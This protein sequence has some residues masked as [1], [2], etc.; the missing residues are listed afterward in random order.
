MLPSILL[1]CEQVGQTTYGEFDMQQ[2]SGRKVH[3]QGWVMRLLAAVSHKTLDGFVAMGMGLSPREAQQYFN[4]STLYAGKTMASQ[5]L[6]RLKV[7]EE[8]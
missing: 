2:I 8:G 3:K 7:G 1:Q 5:S 6:A 4:V